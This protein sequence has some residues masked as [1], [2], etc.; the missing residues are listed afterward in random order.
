MAAYRQ[1]HRPRVACRPP[2]TATQIAIAKLLS[3]GMNPAE[4]AAQLAVDRRTVYFHV[5]Q[6]A[7]R[8]PG[9]LAAAARMMAW[10]RGASLEVLGAN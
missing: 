4:I 1:Q 2:L 9:D 8:I 3:D 5:T 6:A 10:Y 7:Q